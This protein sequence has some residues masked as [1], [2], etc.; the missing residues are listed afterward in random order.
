MQPESLAKYKLQVYNPGSPFPSPKSDPLKAF[1]TIATATADPENPLKITFSTKKRKHTSVSEAESDSPRKK[2]KIMNEE[3]I[4]ALF[5]EV[6]DENKETMNKFKEDFAKQLSDDQAQIAKTL[7]TI[8]TQLGTIVSAQ[9]QA[10]QTAKENDARM[11]AIEDR[12]DIVENKQG[13]TI[14]EGNTSPSESSWIATLAKEVFDHEH[15]LIIHGVKLDGNNDQSKKAAVIK[16]FKEELKASEDLVNK[17]RIRD[18]V[19][20]G[21]E[22]GSGKLPPLLV[23]LGHP[24][25]RNQLLPLSSNLKRGVDIDKSVPKLYLKTHKEFKR[26]AWKLK[27]L[28]NVQTQVVFEGHNMILRYRKKTDGV[29]EYNWE[30]DRE[31]FPKPEDLTASL[32]NTKTKDPNKHDTP[33]ID[34]SSAAQCSKSVIISGVPESVKQESAVSDFN[35]YFKNEDHTRITEIQYKSKGVIVIVCKD[36]VSAKHIAD[37]YKKTKFGDKEIYFTMFSETDPSLR[38]DP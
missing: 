23:K 10:T 35:N 4:K 25:E 9:T 2:S 18:V 22:T 1:P 20:L 7:S 16:F 24:T 12:L 37:S 26:H 36:W 21:S 30:T 13:N 31:W 34:T 27:L 32:Q 11:K 19:R 38:L 15:G 8:T 5:K 28:H 33:K 6:R 29:M 14:D 3:Q 17:I